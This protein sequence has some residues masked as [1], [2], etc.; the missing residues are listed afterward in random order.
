MIPTAITAA[1]A[2]ASSALDIYGAN[3]MNRHNKAIARKQMT[4]QRAS[5][6]EQMNFQERMS[7]TS[8]QRA[9]ADM[10]AAGI[11]PM[12][13]FSQGG[14]ST[15]SGASAAGASIAETNAIS[16]AAHSALAF[17]RA[18]TDMKAVKEQTK[19]TESQNSAAQYALPEQEAK[20]RF[21]N[22]KLGQFVVNAK[23]IMSLIEPLMDVGRGFIGP[24][25]AAKGFKT[26]K[27]FGK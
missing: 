2:L 19:L 13:A 10:R 24:K 11:N 8:Y 6:R 5:A 21:Y 25:T 14:A 9:V 7:N 4:F 22:S 17:K 12:L 1:G 16:G 15:P 3:R 20:A 26:I 23:E 27:G 18:V